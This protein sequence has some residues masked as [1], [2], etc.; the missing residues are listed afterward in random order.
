MIGDAIAGRYVLHE[1][2]GSGGMG[3]VYRAA[4]PSLART[5][6]IKV[7]RP[8]LARDP[9]FVTRFQLEAIA[10]SRVTHPGSVAVIEWGRTEDGTPFIVMED[11]HGV[12]LGRVLHHGGPMP[13][14]RVIEILRQLLAALVEVHA[15]AVVHGDVKTDNLLVETTRDG[16]RVRLIDFGLARLCDASR[17]ADH[18]RPR[19]PEVSGTPEY[20]AP[21]VVSGESPTPAADIYGAGIVLYELLT[22]ATPF[23]GGT[24]SEVMHRH[25]TDA[26]VP[27]SLR[28][29]ERG[30]P[31]ALEQVV[32]RAL[33][34]RPGDRFADA[35]AFATALADAAVAA[36]RYAA[37]RCRCGAVVPEAAQ[38]CTTCGAARRTLDDAARSPDAETRRWGPEPPPREESAARRRIAR[39]SSS[40]DLS[41]GA[42]ERQLRREIGAAIASGDVPAIASGYLALARLLAGTHRERRAARELREG[43]DVVTAGAGLVS[44]DPVA[45]VGDLVRELDRLRGRRPP[46]R[47]SE[48]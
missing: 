42:R 13:V 25:L 8:E 4:Q 5:V 37:P 10:A 29:P 20:M 39:G 48:R 18:A 19:G 34:K 1:R 43:I 31:R 27:P 14:P 23:A 22:G 32:L 9:M 45:P 28:R 46:R 21:E 12:P 16:E 3:I 44:R 35:A 6:A 15:S 36:D 26:V 24:P 2:L 17:H 47:R 40:G 41:P 33:A 7:L 30:I 38:Y 11:V